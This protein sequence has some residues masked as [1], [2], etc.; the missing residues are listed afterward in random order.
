MVVMVAALVATLG[1]LW[2]A[3]S[4]RWQPPAAPWLAAVVPALAA[5][6]LLVAGYLTY[7]ETQSAAAVCGP[8]GDCNAVQT[9]EY[10]RLFGIPIGLIGI[11]GYVAI[12]LVWAW[13][14]Y[15]G[16]D[17]PN[18]LLVSMTVAGVLF[19]IYLTWLELAV[20]RA[21]CIWCVSSAAIMTLLLLTSAGLLAPGEAEQR[22]SL[23]EA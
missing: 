5:L 3:R 9:S 16:R 14:Q 6:G 21:V 23:L 10:A 19:S 4:G 7:V 17:L 20:I 1:G 18:L 11:A 13:G 15:S 12:L 22:Q 2:L 8:V